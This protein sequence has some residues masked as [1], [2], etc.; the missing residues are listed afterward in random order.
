M[1]NI[2][3]EDIDSIISSSGID[4]NIF[5]NSN[6]LITG[7]GGHIGT[8]LVNVLN[9][10]NVRK[11]FNI[12]L[13]LVVR[14]KKKLYKNK[15]IPKNKKIFVIEDYS[16]NFLKKYKKQDFLIHLASPSNSL[17]FVGC[18]ED[19]LLANIVMT[20]KI[21][22]FIIEK[23]IKSFLFASSVEVYGQTKKS[24]LSENSYGYIDIL[25]P[26]SIYAES[27]RVGENLCINLGKKYNL[28]I[29]IA[30]IFHT[31]GPF[32]KKNE[33]K[34]IPEFLFS[35]FNKKK[36]NIFSNGKAER[37][38]AYITDVVAGIFIVLLK[39]KRLNA[40]NIGNPLNTIDINGLAKKIKNLI[41]QIY[42][43]NV[44]IFKKKKRIFD[45][46]IKNSI[47]NIDK[48][49]NIGFRPKINLNDT[50]K[51]TIIFYRNNF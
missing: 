17:N 32:F 1:N 35:S 46:S 4:W 25:N 11:N 19:I 18:G 24:T 5:R 15:Y 13:T 33:K 36:I 9:T 21:I 26:R 38:F 14:N 43:L 41:N 28:P 39:G 45:S 23:K 8:Y 48:I 20:K 30:R 31:C 29:K 7:A 49:R 16:L 3:K 2:L 37:S 44:L 51:R 50:L 12:E 47:P 22:D 27:K 40:Y 42:K 34:V 10:L 6:V